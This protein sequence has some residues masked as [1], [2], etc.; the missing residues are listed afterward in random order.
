MSQQAFCDSIKIAKSTLIRYEKEERLPDAEVIARICEKHHIGYTWL[1]TGKGTPSEG[2]RYVPIRRYDIAAS[3]GKGAFVDDCADI[4]MVMVDRQWLSFQ[5]RVKPDDV[6]M[7][8]VRGDSM[9]PTL[10]HGDG[11]LVN[12]NVEQIGDGIYVLRYGGLLQ[13]KRLQYLPKGII[14][15]TSDNPAYEPYVVDLSEEGLDFKVVGKV[16][17][18][19]KPMNS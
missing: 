11:L 10:T 2:D 19:M 12:S 8:F 5:L 1:I 6:S 18:T 16:I 17:W 7:I 15:V 14:R 4:E 9:H 13:V 3:A